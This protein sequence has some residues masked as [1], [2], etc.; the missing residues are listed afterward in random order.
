MSIN[1]IRYSESFFL[2][3]LIVYPQ[4]TPFITANV[5]T[6]FLQIYF[7]FVKQGLTFS[8]IKGSMIP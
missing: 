6:S 8:H 3:F 2:I 1:K 7:N 5:S 4:V